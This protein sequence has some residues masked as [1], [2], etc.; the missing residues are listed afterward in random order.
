MNPE[1][2]AKIQGATKH[3]QDFP[4]EGVKFIDIFPIVSQPEIFT[5]VIDAF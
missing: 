1:L 3:Y 5:L 4:K 2:A